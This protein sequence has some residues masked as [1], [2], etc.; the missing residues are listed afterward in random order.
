MDIQI[1]EIIKIGTIILSIVGL[2]FK[3]KYDVQK[4][5]EKILE[6]DNKINK[7]IENIPVCMKKFEN[8]ATDINKLKTDDELRNEYQSQIVEK[9]LQPILKDFSLSMK[10]YVDSKIGILQAELTVYQHDNQEFK[11]ELKEYIKE[12]KDENKESI[13]ELIDAIKNK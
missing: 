10:D 9:I 11:K 1:E 4:N 5:S 8:I 12:L 7:H 13:K 2:Y 3:N 6:V